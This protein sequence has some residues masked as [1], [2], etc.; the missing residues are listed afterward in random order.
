MKKFY[1]LSS[2][3]S[4]IEIV[5]APSPA[6][7][8]PM[9]DEA[10]FLHQRT[11]LVHYDATWDTPHKPTDPAFR[12]GNAISEGYWVV[13]IPAGWTTTIPLIASPQD[14][15]NLRR[16]VRDELAPDVFLELEDEATV[17]VATVYRD[18]VRAQMH[19]LAAVRTFDVPNALTSFERHLRSSPR[20]KCKF[21]VRD[22]DEMG[23]LVRVVGSNVDGIA[24][25][26]IERIVKNLIG[27]VTSGAAY[28]E[29]A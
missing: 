25:R 19:R 1:V 12:N 2:K 4:G 13:E 6:D 15:T 14:L 5:S 21:E 28:I 11:Y 10:V 7:A 9:L 20:E 23:R 29:A 18:A 8:G 27:E 22:E 24:I 17:M 3:F 16:R 26:G